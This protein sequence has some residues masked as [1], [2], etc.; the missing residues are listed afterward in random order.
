VLDDIVPDPLPAALAVML[1][2][3]RVKV[4]VT[5]LAADIVTVHVPVPEHP[6]PDQPVKVEPVVALAVNVTDVFSVYAAVPIF[7]I[8]L[9]NPVFGTTLPL[10][11]PDL[12][13]VRLYSTAGF[14]ALPYTYDQYPN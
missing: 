3:F 7:P 13:T 14:T 9:I 4:A 5:F 2:W 12:V 1:Y 11:V 6:S 10:P 8:Q